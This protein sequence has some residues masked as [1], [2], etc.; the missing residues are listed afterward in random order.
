[1]CRTCLKHLPIISTDFGLFPA[2]STMMIVL[3]R[4]LALVVV[5]MA[6]FFRITVSGAVIRHQ[7]P[8]RSGSH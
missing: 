1:M 5:K 2:S 6:L 7:N 8:V 4:P 3:S